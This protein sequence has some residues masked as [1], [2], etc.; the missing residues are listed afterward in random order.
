MALTNFEVKIDTDTLKQFE[1]VC[2]DIG[3]SVNDACVMFIKTCVKNQCIPFEICAFPELSQ[4][5]PEV[6]DVILAT[7]YEL[8]LIISNGEKQQYTVEEIVELIDKIAMAK[9]QET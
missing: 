7:L 9:D 5:D 4:N 8:R 6:Q 3:I 2:D 1:K